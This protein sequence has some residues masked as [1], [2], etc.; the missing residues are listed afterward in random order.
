M[1]Y[2]LVIAKKFPGSKYTSTGEVPSRYIANTL[3]AY[4]MRKNHLARMHPNK[5]VVDRWNSFLAPRR[6]IHDELFGR[7]MERRKLQQKVMHAK[8]WQ[9]ALQAEMDRQGQAAVLVIPER[10]GRD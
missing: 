7:D 10:S 1:K 8:N 3:Q 9:A 5:G 4:K 2:E 6:A